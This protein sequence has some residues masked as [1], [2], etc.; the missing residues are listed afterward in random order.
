MHCRV[1]HGF[2]GLRDVYKSDSMKDDV[3]QSYFFAESLKVIFHNNL[4]LFILSLV[5]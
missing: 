4:Y 5:I 3:Q 1:P 2:S